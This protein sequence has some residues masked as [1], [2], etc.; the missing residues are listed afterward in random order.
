MTDDHRLAAAEPRAPPTD[1][2]RDDN[3]DP[4]FEVDADA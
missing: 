4:I 3:G 1:A 2:P